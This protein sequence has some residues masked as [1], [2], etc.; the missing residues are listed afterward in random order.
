MFRRLRTGPARWAAAATATLALAGAGLIVVASPAYAVPFPFTDSFEGTPTDRWVADAVAG[1]TAVRLGNHASART[2]TK[3]ATLD[4][5]G[6]PMSTSARIYSTVTPDGTPQG[7]FCTVSLYARRVRILPPLPDPL[8]V[9]V[10]LKIRSGGPTG[11]VTFAKA[12]AFSALAWER[13]DVGTIFWPS[14]TFTIDL[15]TY[16][17]TILIDD[18]GFACTPVF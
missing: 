2:G 17:G 12:K 8:S 5:G 4:A 1:K 6:I 18:V 10:Y 3:V 9:E 11:Q 16:Y 13:W 15:A 7:F 14:S